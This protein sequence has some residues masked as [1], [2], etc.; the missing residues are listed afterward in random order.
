VPVEMLTKAG[1]WGNLVNSLSNM[2]GPVLGAAFIA[3]FP[4]AS[5]MLIDIFGAVSAIICLLFVKIPNI[6][7]N[8]EKPYLLSDMK[9]G[10]SVNRVVM[11]PNDP[12]L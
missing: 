6:P 3:M 7:Q 5:I 10:L 12:P 2:L 4:I 11:P 8:S 1:G 9:H